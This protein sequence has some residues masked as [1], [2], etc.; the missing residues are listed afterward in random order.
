MFVRLQS[1]PME[2]NCF[3]IS[4]AN[5][6]KLRH[7]GNHQLSCTPQSPREQICS[8]TCCCQLVR[9]CVRAC[10]CVLLVCMY[11]PMCT[12]EKV[13][14]VKAGRREGRGGK[15]M[16][17]QRREEENESPSTDGVGPDL[18]ISGAKVLLQ[19]FTEISRSHCLS[20]PYVLTHTSLS[21][22][23][24]CPLLLQSD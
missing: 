1:A 24:H 6:K 14:G 4:H 9:A 8:T 17:R 23:N 18:I 11:V 13:S 16:G 22:H 2:A 15:E 5:P 10:T 7:H 21:L 20:L 19:S 3:C 12:C